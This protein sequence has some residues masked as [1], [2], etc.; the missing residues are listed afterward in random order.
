MSRA[1]RSSLAACRRRGWFKAKTASRV[2]GLKWRRRAGKLS[3]AQRQPGVT[4]LLCRHSGCR[5]G[6]QDALRSSDAGEQSNVAGNRALHPGGSSCGPWAI[7]ARV[8]TCVSLARHG[9]PPRAREVL[10]NGKFFGARVAE[11]KASRCRG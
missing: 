11:A 8:G 10:G 7:R 2:D 4:V 1:V 9:T 3:T 5:A 6:P